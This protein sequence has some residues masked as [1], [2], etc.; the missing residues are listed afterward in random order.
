M[1]DLIAYANCSHSPH[2]A[3]AWRH[4]DHE[5]AQRYTELDYWRELGQILETAPFAGLFLADAYNVADRFR[6]SI[7]PTIQQGEQFPE[8]DPLPLLT[9]IAGATDQLGV[10]TTASTSIYPPYLLAKKLSTIDHLTDGRLGWNIVTSSGRLEFANAETARLGHDARYDRADEYLDVVYKLWERSVDDGAVVAN[11]EDGTYADPDRVQFIDH[12][13]EYFALPGPHLVAPSPQRTPL[14]FQAGQSERGKA[15]AARHA[16]ATF[17]F[18]M[19]T[20]SLREYVADLGDRA[21]DNGRAPPSVFP[22]IAPYVAET[23][24]AAQSL[25]ESVVTQTSTETGLVR[26]SNHLDHDYSQYDRDAPLRAIEVDGIRGVLTAFLNSDREWTVGEAAR[27]YAR[28]PVPEPVGTPEQVADTFAAWHAA[29]ADGFMIMTP[30]VPAGF[31]RVADL[32]VPELQRRG[33]MPEEYERG[34]LRARI[35][36]ADRLPETHPG[37]DP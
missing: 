16:E 4:P 30:V 33:L 2:A 27:R 31:E 20:T 3:D 5:H 7:E 23:E 13:G 26:L 29:G 12:E 32:L 25:H 18:Q 37:T 36:A 24:T 17:T 14:L 19:T 35:R 21:Q 11:A 28:H 6:G 15:F 22:G 10:I 8:N 9:S 34:T 1:F